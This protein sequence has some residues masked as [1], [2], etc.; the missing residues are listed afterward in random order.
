MTIAQMTNDQATEAMV[1]ISAVLGP[2]FEDKDVIALVNDL[3]DN[4][5]ENLM[6][7]IPKYL[8]KLTLLAFQRHKDNLYEIVSAIS[9]VGKKDVGTM[10]FK[11]TVAIIAESWD[12]LRAFFPS[13]ASRANTTE[14]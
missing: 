14:N 11:Q 12:D 1:R 4:K 10:N 13:S 5:H 2:I 3:G 8:P 6:T 9:G 7:L